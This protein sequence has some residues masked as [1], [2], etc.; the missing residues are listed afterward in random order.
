MLISG[1]HIFFIGVLSVISLLNERGMQTTP[2]VAHIFQK[3]LLYRR[4]YDVW[5][6]FSV[7]TSLV[8]PLSL[9][10]LPLILC[11]S[12]SSRYPA[13]LARVRARIFIDT[14]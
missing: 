14:E 9:S 13:K 2:R 6:S 5:Q 10:F 8:V 7:I 12:H 1:T 4:R 11:L 3:P